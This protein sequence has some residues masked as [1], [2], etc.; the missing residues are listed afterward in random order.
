MFG[1]GN[2]PDVKKKKLISYSLSSGGGMNGGHSSTQIN[3]INGETILTELHSEWWYEDGQIA[4][5]KLDNA[6]L[7]DIEKVFRKHK[8]QKW[9]NK[10]FSNIFVADGPS[11]CHT[12]TF[13]EKTSVSF[14]SQCFPMIYAKKLSEINSVIE[15]YKSEGSPEPRL[16]TAKKTD[17]ELVKNQNPS[18]GKIEL[19]VYQY[20]ADS[21]S[22][23][24]LNGTNEN[25]SIGNNIKLVRNSDGK[26]L[27][28]TNLFYPIE[29]NASST[30]TETLRLKERLS[31]GVYTLSAG[32]YS[33]EFEIRLPD[34]NS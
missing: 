23:R 21:L 22:F 26:T 27:V 1:L 34:G 15:R 14:S 6:V 11:F 5:Y 31:E 3:I 19:E 8:M 28:E 32:D 33:D 16:V 25:A 29:P 18:N 12:F 2:V 9:N 17:E 10:V 13:E 24:V 20:S 4:E 7:A 30:E